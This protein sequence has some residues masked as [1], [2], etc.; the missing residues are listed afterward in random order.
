MYGSQIL[1]LTNKDFMSIC[2][3]R[4]KFMLLREKLATKLS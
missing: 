2:L 4:E 1:F 3:K